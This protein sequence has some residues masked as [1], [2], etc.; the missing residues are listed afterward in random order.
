VTPARPCR[1]DTRRADQ[2]SGPARGAMGVPSA[3]YDAV[4][5]FAKHAAGGLQGW[6]AI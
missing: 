1:P 2:L 3:Y 4:T 6:L 5:R